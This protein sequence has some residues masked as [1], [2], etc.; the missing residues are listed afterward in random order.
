MKKM[1]SV[2][3]FVAIAASANAGTPVDLALW[4]FETTIP[5]TA[6]PHLAEGGLFAATSNA[7]GFHAGATAYSNP[8]G[9]GSVESFSSTNWL[10]GDYYQFTT[11]TL[12]YESIVLTFDQASSNT[13]PRD[14]VVQ[15][16]S[17]G[18]NFTDGLQYQVL[19]NATPNPTW[20]S[21]GSRL[22]EYTTSA[23]IPVDN[24]AQLWV[25]L[26]NNS[27]ISANG[28]TVASGGTNRVDNVQISGV[29][30]PTPGAVGLFGVAGF[31]AARRR[32]A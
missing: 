16:S 26:T 17:D 7:L 2:A 31:V 24:A 13:G 4:T 23:S 20:S 14:F 30:I 12:G 9:N 19:A 25:R 10:M 15:Y 11:S 21:V 32:R 29:L 22:S 1:I 3:A 8:V 28:G 18:V 27:T 6:G 5:T